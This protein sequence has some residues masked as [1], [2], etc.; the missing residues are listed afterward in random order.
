MQNGRKVFANHVSDKALITRIYN[1]LPLSVGDM[2]QG[3]KWM[4]E[5]AHSTDP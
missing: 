3:N 1:S 4:P 5:T 2:F